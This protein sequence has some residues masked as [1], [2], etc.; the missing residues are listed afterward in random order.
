MLIQ[1][2]GRR[3]QGEHLENLISALGIRELYGLV[4]NSCPWMIKAKAVARAA[5]DGKKTQREWDLVVFS[6][7]WGQGV[8]LPE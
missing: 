6:P 3:L 5:W 2:M 8:C 4:C 7:W 1:A